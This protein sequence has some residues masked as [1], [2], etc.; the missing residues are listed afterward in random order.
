[1]AL[2]CLWTADSITGTGLALQMN[3]DAVINVL[4]S[5]VVSSNYSKSRGKK[6]RW[7]TRASRSKPWSA[8]KFFAFYI[9]YIWMLYGKAYV[10]ATKNFFALL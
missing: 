1:V 3:H 10:G 5:V 7:R 9:L 6:M 2:A 4:Y 8:Q